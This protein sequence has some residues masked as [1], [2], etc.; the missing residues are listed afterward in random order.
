MLVCC[1]ARSRGYSVGDQPNVIC[2]CIIHNNN[3]LSGIHTTT[4]T[5]FKNILY[6]ANFAHLT[7]STSETTC[8]IRACVRAYG[9]CM[10]FYSVACIEFIW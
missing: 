9:E 10:R 3:N 5:I 4:C 7:S 2:I 6:E 1:V 8:S